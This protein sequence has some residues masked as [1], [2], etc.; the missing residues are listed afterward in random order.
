MAWLRCSKRLLVIV[1]VGA[2][3]AAGLAA[4]SPAGAT[5]RALPTPAPTISDFQFLTG[6]I[7]PPTEAQCFSAVPVQRRCF[8]PTSMQ[9]SY[10]LAPLYAA[11]HNG[12][13]VT[14]AII[15]SFGNPN[16]AS[17]LNVFNTQMGTPHMCGE[18]GVT[19][20]SGMPTFQHVYWNGKT[21]VKAPPSN[22]NGA[23]LQTRNIWAL[24]VALDVEWAH[25]IAPGANILNVT[26]N[27]AETLGVQGFPAM[28]NAE[29]YIIDHHLATVISQS[30]ASAEE[31]F[32]STRSLLNLRHAFVSAAAN[33]VTMLGSSGDGGSA[34]SKKTPVKN[35]VT[36]PFPTVE[37]PA[38]DPLVTAVGGTY[39]C[40]NPITGTGVDNT[41]P[42]VECQNQPNREIGWIASGGGFSHV[43]AKPSYQNT[44]PAGSTPIGSTRGVPDIAYQA[45]SRTG[46]LVY[47]TAPGDAEGGVRCPGGDPCSAGWYVVGGT[48]SG[49]PQ[50]AGLVAIADQI[51][52]HGLGLINPKLYALAAGPNYG[53][54]FYDVTTG[55]NQADP[56]VPGFPATTGWDPV[57][58]LGTPNAATLLPALAS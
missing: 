20:S 38:S 45:S 30:F 46:V 19:C 29:Q 8:T 17:D 41:D 11:G 13:G 52:G 56:D 50:W 7:T 36:F 21:M 14:I 40:T 3:A 10:N 16:M 31:A 39:L 37:W 4:G 9:N 54:Y 24:E 47:D 23:G 51:A 33:G 28:M 32:A 55:N 6:S 58:G 15:D 35:P 2:L 27:P 57:T 25:A 12:K 5:A 43:F 1:A 44:L 34:N 53:T 22:S 48:S 49:S 18:P 26:T 42:P